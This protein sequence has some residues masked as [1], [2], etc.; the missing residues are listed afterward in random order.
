MYNWIHDRTFSSEDIYVDLSSCKLWIGIALD[1]GVRLDTVI[2]HIN[3]YP[4]LIL[5]YLI[6][7][8]DDE[9]IEW[10]VNII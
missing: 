6:Q 5:C 8:A 9:Y 4:Y 3:S 2:F 1:F 10:I 7:N